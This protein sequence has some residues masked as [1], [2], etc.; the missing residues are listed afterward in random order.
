[1]LVSL[2]RIRGR[3]VDVQSEDS[4]EAV[5]KRADTFIFIQSIAS[6]QRSME[7]IGLGGDTNSRIYQGGAM[8]PSY[9][10][11]FQL[12]DVR[13]N[14]WGLANDSRQPRWNLFITSRPIIGPVA[15]GTISTVHVV[16]FAGGIRCSGPGLMM[17]TGFMIGQYGAEQAKQR[18]EAAI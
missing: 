7:V 16:P 1:M 10:T 9:T 17:I 8:L 13:E 12:G 3:P 2:D 15:A 4:S 14:S 6:D 11:S 5:L 18:F